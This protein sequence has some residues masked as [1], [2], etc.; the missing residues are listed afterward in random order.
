MSGSQLID[1]AVVTIFAREVLEGA[2]IIGE[3]RTIIIR[4]DSLKPGITKEAALR[5]VTLSALFATALALL[6]IAA[7]AIPLGVLSSTFDDFTSKIIEGVSK[8]VA[9]LSLL[10]LS[11][12]FPKWL[13]IYG[14]SKKK[15]KSSKRRQR[16]NSESK[17]ESDVEVGGSD[18]D[19]R[20]RMS[21]PMDRDQDQDSS[22]KE[23]GYCTC[24][25]TTW[26][27][28]GR[29]TCT[30]GHRD[31]EQVGEDETDEE[32]DDR[33]SGTLTLR[34]I[35]F[36]VAWN[37]WREVAECGVFLIPFFLSGE[38]LIAIPLSALVGF[39]VGLILG[40]GIYFANKR[41]KDKR[42]LAVLSVLLLVFLSAGLFSGG[43]HNLESQLG[44]TRTVWH[45]EGQ[46]WSV[47]RLPM[48]ILK[49]FG[50][51]DTRTVLQIVT[52]WCW[53]GLSAILHLR[54]YL[55][56]PRVSQDDADLPPLGEA[57]I[58][59]AVSTLGAEEAETVEMGESSLEGD[60]GRCESS[61]DGDNIVPA[62][63]GG[64]EQPTRLENLPTQ[65]SSRPERP[66]DEDEI[67]A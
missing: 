66:Q 20:S 44:Q 24:T 61:L 57:N 42:G 53:L 46:F 41:L 67:S 25:T 34:S 65:T 40:L 47:N 36:N 56:S 5:E 54:K 9:A 1:F 32:C 39:V 16:S 33:D 38:G 43:C 55:I 29:G 58:P 26:K 8:I 63:S 6:V 51:S 3:Y 21:I 48:T 18:E 60:Y 4:G 49:P 62:Q 19:D 45:I 37:I 27:L 17:E 2:I 50:Y 64:E 13:G 7:V 22:A 30:R 35:R 10:Q 31:G 23:K 52:F 28:C 59:P 15:K 11:L 14:S 12:K